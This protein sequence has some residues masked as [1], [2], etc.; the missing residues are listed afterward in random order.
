MTEPK[1]RADFLARL[2]KHV[3]TGDYK[4]ALGV[5]KAE[6]AKYPD[7]FV[8]Q[9]QYARLLGDW[10][11][12]LPEAR[13]KKLKAEA[14]Q[15]LRPMTG[16]LSGKSVHERFAVCLNY[17]YQS[18]AYKSMYLFGRRFAAV[19]RRYGLYCQALGAALHAEK[20]YKERDYKT[21]RR[22]AEKAVTAW[23]GYGLAKEEYY[24]AHYT[25]AKALAMAGDKRGAQVALRAAAKLSRRKV[26]DWEFAD[27]REM[28]E[29]ECPI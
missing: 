2:A 19:D 7:N 3:R 8:C 12:E 28:I 27:A 4:T 6:L 21:M 26:S 13:K 22:W 20:A 25:Y 10:A 9:Y 16:A 29:T 11:D 24:F 15:L 18:H 14:V 23:R 17:Y 5:A 1:W